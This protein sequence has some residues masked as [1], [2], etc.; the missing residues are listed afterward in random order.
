MPSAAILNRETTSEQI[1]A[2]PTRAQHHFFFPLPIRIPDIFP[3][4]PRYICL[5]VSTSFGFI[6]A[7]ILLNL[8]VSF[9]CLDNISAPYREHD[10]CSPSVYNIRRLLCVLT[11]FFLSSFGCLG[12]IPAR[13][14]ERRLCSTSVTAADSSTSRREHHLV[15]FSGG[16][17]SMSHRSQMRV[18]E[19]VYCGSRS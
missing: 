12:N 7:D 6:V 16:D 1:D 17:L 14:R 11:C 5:Y 4:L 2:N 3:H 19:R 15:F 10:S 8:A 18:G 9:R 13:R